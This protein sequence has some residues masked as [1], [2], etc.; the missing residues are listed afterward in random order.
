MMIPCWLVLLYP[1]QDRVGGQ[2]DRG[3]GSDDDGCLWKT[4]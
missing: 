1:I 3:F 4:Q 2:G